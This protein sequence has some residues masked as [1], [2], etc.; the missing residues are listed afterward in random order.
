MAPAQ[1][2]SERLNQANG[3]IHPKEMDPAIEKPAPDRRSERRP[4][5]E[6][7]RRRSRSQMSHVVFPVV[8]RPRRAAKASPVV[9]V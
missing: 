4:S 3:V 9:A 7:F 1:N 5:G 6:E 8:I 2:L